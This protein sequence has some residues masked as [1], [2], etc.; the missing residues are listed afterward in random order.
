MNFPRRWT[1]RTASAN[2]SAPAATSAQYSPSEWPATAAGASPVSARS[3]RSAAML[4]VRIAGWAFAVSVSSAS[5]P[6]KQSF[7]SENPSAASASAK[8]ARASRVGL[9]ERAPHADLLRALAGEEKRGGRRRRH[10]HHL[11]A[12]EAQASPPPSAEKSRRS[13]ALSFPCS[14]ASSSAV[15]TDADEVLP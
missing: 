1:R 2:F 5:G 7:D 3:T 11:T 8:T 10:A 9:V 4:D 14:I 12:A 13:P 15:G 6:S